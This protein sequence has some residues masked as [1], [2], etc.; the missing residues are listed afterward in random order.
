MQLEIEF[1]EGTLN[2]SFGAWIIKLI[3]E[4]TLDNVDP[5]KLQ[6]LDKY[7]EENFIHLSEKKKVTCIDIINAGLN[8]LTYDFDNTKFTIRISNHKFMQGL[9]RIRIET[10]C[11]L[12]NYGTASIKG[13]P[14]F[15]DSFNQIAENIDIYIESYLREVQYG[16]N[17][18]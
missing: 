10:L 6:G 17:I 7:I 3:R 14:I 4:I 12:I 13:Y 1:K 2:R 9:D 8:E 5:K 16:S 11:K 18:I 15:T